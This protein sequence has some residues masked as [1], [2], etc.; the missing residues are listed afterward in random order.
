MNC[1]GAPCGACKF[2]RRKCVKGCV[3][4]PYFGS[5]EGPAHFA[6]VHKIFGASNVSKLLLHIP[7]QE[8]CEAVVTISYEAEARLRDPVYGCVAHIYALQQQVASLQA[9][10]AFMQAELASRVSSGSTSACAIYPVMSDSSYSQHPHQLPAPYHMIPQPYNPRVLGVKEENACGFANSM[11]C[12]FSMSPSD[13]SSTQ[14]E[15]LQRCGNLDKTGEDSK[16]LEALAH[17]LLLRG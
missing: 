15:V 17:A 16:E 6:A 3:F 1:G 14:M 5:E 12:E 8:R 10:L 13:N 2:L 4:A 11:D 9:E 7:M